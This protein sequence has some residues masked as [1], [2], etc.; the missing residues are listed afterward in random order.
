M[1]PAPQYAFGAA[2]LS[3]ASAGANG[4]ANGPRTSGTMGLD[5]ASTSERQTGAGWSLAVGVASAASNDPVRCMDARST[6]EAYLGIY[7]T[8]TLTSLTATEPATTVMAPT[9]ELVTLL[10]TVQ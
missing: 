5:D 1:Q 9:S 10:P 4:I 3:P 6:V 2:I 7:R 8:E